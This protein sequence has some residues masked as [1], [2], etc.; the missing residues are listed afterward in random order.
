MAFRQWADVLIQNLLRIGTRRLNFWPLLFIGG[1]IPRDSCLAYY[2]GLYLLR[3]G[4]FYSMALEVFIRKRKVITG[5]SLLD[6]PVSALV[7][8]FL[9]GFTSVAGSN[10]P[11]G[12]NKLSS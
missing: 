8:L 10:I 11:S 5:I 3:F 4:G 7:G 12:E 2:Y 6:L 9:S 1:G